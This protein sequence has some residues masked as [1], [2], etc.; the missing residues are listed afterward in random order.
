M[1]ATDALGCAWPEFAAVVLSREL[2]DGET[3]SP[4]GSRSEIPLAAARLAQLT[5]APNLSIIT[6]AVGFVANV[7]G[8]PCGPLCHSTMD[9]RN[10]YCGTE[11]VMASSGVFHTRRDWF[12]AGA[13]Q[14]D[15]F[16]NLNL[17]RVKLK[18]GGELRGPGAA[19]LAY[20]SSMAKRYFVYM[21]EHSTRSFVDTLDYRTAIGF[22]E[23]PG[24]R[25]RLRLRGGGPALVVSPR[26]VMDFDEATK[27]LRLRS[28]HPGQSLDDLL[29]NTGCELVVPQ[30]VPRTPVP[31]RRELE[32]LRGFVDRAGVLRH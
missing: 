27:R 5:H 15:A 11:A 28:L 26:A 1:Q 7:S 14:V 30:H 29:A 17:N 20:S 3:G 8:K 4:G 25:E 31:T 16:G 9:W 24:S 21:H 23:G 13:L 12:F 18:D 10:I 2:R 19:G 22:G 32:L 6:S